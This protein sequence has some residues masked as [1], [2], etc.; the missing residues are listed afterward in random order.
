M[1]RSLE[2]P[3]QLAFDT[4]YTINTLI[5]T[6]LRAI[7]HNPEMYP[8]PETF[9]PERHEAE[10]VPHPIECGVFGYGRRQVGTTIASVQY[11]IASSSLRSC[12]G[13]NMALDTVWIAMATILAVFDIEKAV[14]EN[15]NVITP[16]VAFRRSTIK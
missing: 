7:M 4:D 16:A 14:D 1:R 13:K 2:T 5:I 15:G 8:D 10:G 6:L 9:K 11:L 12:S 3:G